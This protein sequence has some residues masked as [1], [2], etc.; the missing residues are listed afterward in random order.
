MP[1]ASY[2]TITAST[3]RLCC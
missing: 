1:S 3:I 2:H